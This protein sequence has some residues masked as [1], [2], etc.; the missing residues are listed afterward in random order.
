VAELRQHLAF[1]E[2]AETKRMRVEEALRGS[3][4][5]FRNLVETI[6]DWI[7]EV[8]LR[9]V[10]T[11]VSPRVRDMLGYEPKELLGKTPF[12]TMPPQEAARMRKIF[13]DIV[14]TQ[15]SF[16]PIENICLHKDGH[17][18]ILET[19]GVPFFAADGTLMG[20]RGVDRDIT[21]RKRGEE[22]LRKS[23]EEAKRLAQ[24]TAIMAEIGKIISSTLNIEEVYERF[25][26][27]VRKLIPFDRI[28]ISA[29]ELGEHKVKIVYNLGL[30]VPK[31]R[32]GSSFPL[33]N[34]YMGEVIRTRSSLLVNPEAMEELINR[35]VGYL[36]AYQAGLRA[37]IS[38]PLFSRDELVGV[39]NLS[40]T[41]QIPYTER[42]LRLA[43]K[44][45][46][47]VSG[48]IANALIFAELKRVEEELRMAQSVLETR[49]RKR[50]AELVKTNEQLQ[51][52]IIE[53]KNAEE[54]LKRAKEGAEAA[55]IAKSA[56]LANMSHE[57]RTPLNSII[58]FSELMADGQA[59][60]LN[61]TQKEYLG[62]VLQSSRHLLS[63]INDIL[64]LAKV[65]AGKLQLEVGEV[66]LPGLL[67]NSLA[68]FKEKSMRQGIQVRMEINGIPEWIGGDQQKLE[69]ILCN[70]LSNALKFTPDG[71]MV[72]LGACRLFFGD[73]QWTRADGGGEPIPFSPSLAG[74]WVGIFIR[75]TG[76]GLKKEDL[77]RIFN[78]FEQADNSASRR[79]QG[80]G[81]GLALAQKFVEL[82]GGKIWAESQGPGKGSAF[83]FLIPIS[84][85]KEEDARS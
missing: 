18:A 45:G 35:F 3:E 26:A 47:Q 77:A 1:L 19:S 72:T 65:E 38:V 33:A 30:D 67:Q 15:K 44:V 83:R 32:T 53:R 21:E 85:V 62:D 5:R 39:M 16:D 58:G 43:E 36:P 13:E 25:A 84:Q 49:V 57:L 55:S 40:S 46:N 70:L 54:S 59:G 6:K 42:E 56:F 34:S 11:Y 48:A 37:L 27:E 2:A 20:Y 80:T 12:D 51:T 63:L 22:A 24:E 74:E 75:D 66:Y 29:K 73:R 78:P 28:S 10:Y 7:W 61:E 17:P 52:E 41:G 64:D 71:G 23:E 8:D 79:Y 82:H 60:E 76:I 14:K 31:R 4:E 69:Q 68:L 9:G 50:T 81:L